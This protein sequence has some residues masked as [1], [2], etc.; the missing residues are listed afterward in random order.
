[1]APQLAPG[2][3]WVGAVDWDLRYFHG[4]I[5]QRGSSY[6]AYLIVDEKIAL[7]DTVKAPLAATLLEHVTEIV[8]PEKIAF[9]P[10]EEISLVRIG[11]EELMPFALR[12]LPVED[13]II[14]S[15]TLMLPEV[16]ETQVPEVEDIPLTDISILPEVE[17]MP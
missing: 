7:I 17:V 1:M 3:Y 9:E 14:E 13:S 5:T 11:M 10:P 8:P 6:N 16:A 4:Y 15:I 2:I 12:L